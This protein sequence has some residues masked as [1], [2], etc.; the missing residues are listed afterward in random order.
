MKGG[1]QAFSPVKS[2]A[3]KRAARGTGIRASQIL[4]LL[5]FFSSLT[6]LISCHKAASTSSVSVAVVVSPSS[7]S[8]NVNTSTTFFATVQGG[9]LDTVTWDV[10]GTTGGD[11][12][13]G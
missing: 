5:A 2:M 1:K 8:L 13:V 11:A 9:T 7:A 12:T 3:S 10:N 6:L 4:P